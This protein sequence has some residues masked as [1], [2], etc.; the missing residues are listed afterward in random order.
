MS[1]QPYQPYQPA[2]QQPQQA[3]PPPPPPGYAPPAQFTQP[4]YQQPAPTYQ[5][6]AQGYGQ[7]QQPQQ[8]L[9]QVSIDDFYNQQSS[10]DGPPVSFANWRVGQ[11]M[12]AIVARDVN[13]GDIQV[14]TY[15]QRHPQAGQV[16]YQRD[17]NPKTQMVI[18]LRVEPTTEW[19]AGECRLFVKGQMRDALFEA[20]ERAGYPRGVVPKGGDSFTCIFKEERQMGGGLNP[21]KIYRFDYA[22]GPGNLPGS[23]GQETQ[24]PAPQP[25]SQPTPPPPAPNPPT[26]QAPPPPPPPP[27]QP[28]PPAP[29][30]PAMPAQPPP[31]PPPPPGAAAQGQ[32]P[33][34]PPPADQPRI[35]EDMTE[36][37]AARFNQVAGQAPP[38]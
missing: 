2:P 21:R 15:H 17:G 24:A 3:P 1:Q 20:M 19:P 22:A 26:A 28:G 32:P 18:P 33:P 12:Q 38:Q 35:P 9:P 23:N 30:P 37:Q 8:P 4:Q 14:Q 5:P 31:P 6:P 13:D 36:E 16:I 10:A 34:P 25:A 29:Q 11:W 27:A 7:Q